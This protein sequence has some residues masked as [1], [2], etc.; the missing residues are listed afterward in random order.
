M[1]AQADLPRPV[2]INRDCT[3][4]SPDCHAIFC[5]PVKLP[6]TEQKY[7]AAVP[8]LGNIAVLSVPLIAKE[9][10]VRQASVGSVSCAD[11]SEG[12]R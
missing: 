11:P 2:E 5:R 12:K 3:A 8:D 10:W 1:E 4:L 9:Y 6:Q 7:L